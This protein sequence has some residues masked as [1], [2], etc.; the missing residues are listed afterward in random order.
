MESVKGVFPNESN[1]VR[2]SNAGQVETIS[3]CRFTN[4]S[5][6]VR[7]GNASQ[8]SAIKCVFPDGGDAI[9]NGIGRI[10]FS[11]GILQE[12]GLVF[13][14]QVAVHRGIIRIVGDN[15]NISQ[16]SAI[17]KCQWIN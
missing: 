15:S 2:D 7:N 9:R 16:A 6:A 1:T 8:I 17:I 14:K 3:K 11:R 13:V 10:T 5:D 12:L 4:R